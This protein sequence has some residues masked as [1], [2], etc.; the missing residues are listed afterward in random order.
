MASIDDKINNIFKNKIEI[1]HNKYRKDKSWFDEWLFD[2]H[3][4]FTVNGIKKRNLITNAGRS[5]LANA[6]IKNRGFVLTHCW[7]TSN[8]TAPDVGDTTA[9]FCDISTDFSHVRRFEASYA[10]NT[11]IDLTALYTEP[12]ANFDI[13]KIGV[14]ATVKNTKKLFAEQLKTITTKTN[15]TNMKINYQITL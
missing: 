8:D 7:V 6:I 13:Y 1:L 15:L 10:L 4:F 11:V 14:I 5:M 9:D 3:G 2:L 12:E